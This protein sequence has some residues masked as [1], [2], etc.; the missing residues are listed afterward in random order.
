[1]LGRLLLRIVAESSI[2]RQIYMSQ[3]VCTINYYLVHIVYLLYLS[4]NV[5]CST[6]RKKIYYSFHTASEYFLSYLL[7][8]NPVPYLAV[9]NEFLCTITL[10]LL[11]VNKMLVFARLDR[12]DRNLGCWPACLS[13]LSRAG[14]SMRN[15]GE[16]F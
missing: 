8:Y 3:L 2:F 1:M 11:N 16:H 12:L 10:F 14:R 5:L 13:K 4:C 6:L 9:T 7:N 15:H